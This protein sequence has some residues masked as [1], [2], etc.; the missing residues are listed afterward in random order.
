MSD[1]PRTRL[2]T[3]ALAAVAGLVVGAGGAVAV[4]AT[5]PPAP[6][7][8]SET[9]L[10]DDDATTPGAE[11]GAG[12]TLTLP[13]TIGGMRPEAEVVAA[14]GERAVARAQDSQ[15]VLDELADTLSA[16][17]AGAGAT[18]ATYADD[19]LEMHIRVFAV[20][21]PSPGLWSSQDAEALAEQLGLARPVEW[22]ERDGDAECLVRQHSNLFRTGTDPADV[23]HQVI[24]CQLVETDLTVLL[25]GPPSLT[26]EHALDLIREAADGVQRG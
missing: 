12:A 11:A 22:V 3:T 20:A 9:S 10:T 14:F 6:P 17:H 23:E 26:L 13:A 4:G 15:R 18:S 16:A 19:D 5:R 21:A 24:L 7:A 25:E 8:Q 2:W 1:V